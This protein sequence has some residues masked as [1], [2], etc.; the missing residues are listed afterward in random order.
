MS[1]Q[2]SRPK[3]RLRRGVLWT[4]CFL[5][6]ITISGL[7]A[8]QV[9][10]KP[11]YP[12]GSPHACGKMLGLGLRLFAKDHDGWFPYGGSTAEESLS[13]LCTNQDPYR[14]R[15]LMRGKHLPQAVVDEALARDGVLGPV[16]C[17]WHYVEGLH[18]EDSPSLA[19]VW[20]R[21]TGV[22]HFGQWS[23]SLRCEVTLVDGSQQQISVKKWPEFIQQQKELL[24]ETM[25]NRP[26]NSPPIRWSDEET[27]GPNKFPPPT[28]S[29]PK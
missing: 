5:S 24:A 13:L 20:D 29:K 21:V 1:N 7:V 3:K 16:S 10:F 25:A 9:W 12:Y 22:N 17:G 23:K 8:Y 19:I 26:S 4:V 2:D 6:A 27:L 15:L 11:K 28:I 18:Q 14:I